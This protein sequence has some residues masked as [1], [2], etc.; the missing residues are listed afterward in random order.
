MQRDTDPRRYEF[1]R[2]VSSRCAPSVN[3]AHSKWVGMRVIP[4]T[5]EN[6]SCKVAQ[7]IGVIGRPTVSLS[8]K[9]NGTRVKGIAEVLEMLEGVYGPGSGAWVRQALAALFETKVIDPTASENE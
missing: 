5:G 1:S 9:G 3:G 8:P 7:L 6:S 4:S 2:R